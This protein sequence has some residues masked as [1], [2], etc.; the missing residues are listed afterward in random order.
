M[1]MQRPKQ[2]QLMFGKLTL[3]ILVECIC[4]FYKGML[5]AYADF[6]KLFVKVHWELWDS[7]QLQRISAKVFNFFDCP[8]LWVSPVSS[9]KH[10]HEPVLSLFHNFSTFVWTKCLA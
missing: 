1:K 4:E 7:F 3:H 10:E 2:S 6:K 8:I 9:N 5:A